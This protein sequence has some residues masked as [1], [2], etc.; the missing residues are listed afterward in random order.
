VLVEAPG[1]VSHG[2]AV[3]PDALAAALKELAA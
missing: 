1:S 2:H 3:D